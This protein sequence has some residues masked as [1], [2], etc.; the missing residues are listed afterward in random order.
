[1]GNRLSKIYTRTGDDGTTGLGDG[2]RV[3]KDS[4]RMEAIGTVDELNSVIGVML[5]CEMPDA[6]REIFTKIQHRLFDVGGELCMPG[7]QIID[8][9]DVAQLEDVLDQY[10]DTIPPL[11]NFI[12]PGGTPTAANCHLARAVCRRAERTM[13]ALNRE[14]ALNPPIMKYVN[15]LSDWLFVCSRVLNRLNDTD[16][17]V[18]WQPKQTIAKNK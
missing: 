16:S 13:V 10:N 5:T 11:K 17:E 8:D 2:I 1:M 15:R 9:A 6:I 18:L 7:Y 14:E 4:L 3:G 12:L